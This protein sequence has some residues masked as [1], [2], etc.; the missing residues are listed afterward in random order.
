MSSLPSSP[1]LL[2]ISGQFR[3][4]NRESHHRSRYLFKPVACGCFALLKLAPG[5]TFPT[6][7]SLISLLPATMSKRSWGVY[8]RL[9][10]PLHPGIPLLLY[11]GSA[12]GSCGLGGR[13]RSHVSNM[14]SCRS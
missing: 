2:T 9:G 8:L 10:I 3:W 13:L 11:I 14:R 1:R 5:E 4:A 12:T 7:D 6:V